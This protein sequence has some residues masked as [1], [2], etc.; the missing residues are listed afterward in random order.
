MSIDTFGPTL[1]LWEANP[2]EWE[3]SFLYGTRSGEAPRLQF[4]TDSGL[5]GDSDDLEMDKVASRGGLSFYR[6][7]VKFPLT[8]KEQKVSY[9]IEGRGPFH[10]ALPKE[11]HFPRFAYASCNGFHDIR[12]IREYNEH[13]TAVWADMLRVHKKRFHLLLFGGDQVYADSKV[14]QFIEEES[15][16]SWFQSASKK[17]TTKL[18]PSQKGKLTELFTNLYFNS[19][20]KNNPEMMEMQATCPTLMMWDDHDIVDGWGSLADGRES[21]PVYQEVY[22]AARE[23]FL[24]FQQHCKPSEDIGGKIP[25]NDNLTYGMVLGKT[26]LIH[27]DTRSNRSPTQILPTREWKR[28]NRWISKLPVDVQHLMVCVSIPLVYADFRWI[29]EALNRLPFDQGI[30]DDLRDQWRSRHHRSTRL[31]LLET[32]FECSH[33]R[34]CRVTVVS[35]DVHVAAHGIIEM[36]DGEHDFKRCS[37][38]HQLVSSPIVNRPGHPVL[39]F[40]L[41]MQEESS[42]DISPS[43]SARMSPLHFHGE[44]KTTTSYYPNFRNWLS[45]T[46]DT[47]GNYRAEWYFEGGRAPCKKEV[48]LSDLEAE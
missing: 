21:W 35:G 24:L 1:K 25:G 19:W 27:L 37:R 4:E 8:T 32:L 13:A 44:R 12:H 43:I 29:E 36:R 16:W 7:R 15:G 34:P 42:E 22:A 28:I 40:Y 48:N 45:F 46:A 20:Q 47:A 9:D 39:D 26:A 38:I 33:S 31:K 14:D 41:G 10:F 6:V 18:T 23:A 3:I 30:E 2:S 5:D 11:D 17:K